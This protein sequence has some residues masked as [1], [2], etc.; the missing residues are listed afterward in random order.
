MRDGAFSIIR[1]TLETRYG[2]NKYIYIKVIGSDGRRCSEQSIH[3]MS[4]NHIIIIT[5]SYNEENFLF[6][7][8]FRNSTSDIK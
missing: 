6:G 4:N 7:M 5:L 1:K 3:H 8:L 2:L